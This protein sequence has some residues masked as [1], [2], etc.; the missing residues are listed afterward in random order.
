MGVLRG[1]KFSNN[2]STYIP[3]IEPALKALKNDARVTKI[4]LG[5]I[6]RCKT[7][8]SKPTARPILAGAK[9][10]FKSNNAVQVIFVYGVTATE[11]QDICGV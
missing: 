4:V 2:H 7:Q 8:L 10:I 5:K 9:L 11:A 6:A 1:P 3:G